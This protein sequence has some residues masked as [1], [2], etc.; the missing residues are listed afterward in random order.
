MSDVLVAIGHGNTGGLAI[1][2]P[3]P[4]WPPDK[5][6]RVTP[7]G[8]G[9]VGLQA[10]YFPLSFGNTGLHQTLWYPV[11]AQFGLSI[12]NGI[13]N[14]DVTIQFPN[15]EDG[16]TTNYNATARYLNDGNRAFGLFWQSTILIVNPVSF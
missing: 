6:G 3:Q 9:S 11:L 1:V 15:E 5:Y 4:M 14:C 8:G 2:A 16:T 7:G 12:K 10:K 13:S